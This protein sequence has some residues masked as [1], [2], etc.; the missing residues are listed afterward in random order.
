MN[1]YIGID[2][3]RGISIWCESGPLAAGQFVGSA[4]EARA[5]VASVLLKTKTLDKAVVLIEKPHIGVTENDN[6]ASLLSNSESAGFL[7][8][9]LTGRVRHVELVDAQGW[10]KLFGIQGKTR[11]KSKALAVALS[12]KLRTDMGVPVIK[13]ER[14]GLLVDACEADLLAIA[15]MEYAR[16]LGLSDPRIYMTWKETGT[17]GVPSA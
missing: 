3:P 9:I 10:R 14:G 1:L 6:K 13:G 12:A 2:T 4:N 7:L 15:A 17:F 16:R 8:G 5:E 11:A